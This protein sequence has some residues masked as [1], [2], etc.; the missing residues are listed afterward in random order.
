MDHYKKIANAEKRAKEP[1]FTKKSEIE[2]L[3][4]NKTKKPK[5]K[6]EEIPPSQTYLQ[7]ANKDHPIVIGKEV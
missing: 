4:R 6:K 1:E 3:K 2:T 7:S 5:S